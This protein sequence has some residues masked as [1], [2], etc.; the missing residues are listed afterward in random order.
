V[1]LDDN[2]DDDDEVQFVGASKVVG[3]LAIVT[4]FI[5]GGSVHVREICHLMTIQ[6]SKQ[7]S[8]LIFFF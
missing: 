7:F 4:E 1:E 5:E 2:D 8:L 3:K 6:T